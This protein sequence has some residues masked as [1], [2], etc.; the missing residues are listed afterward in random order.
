MLCIVSSPATTTTTFYLGH[1]METQ[2]VTTHFVVGVDDGKVKVPVDINVGHSKVEVRPYVLQV[3]I[4]AL[5][6]LRSAF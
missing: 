2:G 3:R 1:L 5:C 4:V 6:R